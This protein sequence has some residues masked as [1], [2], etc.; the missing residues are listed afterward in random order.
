MIIVSRTNSDGSL[1]LGLAL[2]RSGAAP[3]WAAV[4]VVLGGLFPI[5][6]LTGIN[7]LALPIAALRIAGSVPLIK[8]LLSA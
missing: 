3:A 1:L 5:A 2:W 8:T 6:L 7:A 4:C